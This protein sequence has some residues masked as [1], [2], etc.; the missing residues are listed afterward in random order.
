MFH[1][2]DCTRKTSRMGSHNAMTLQALTY[3]E[4]HWR[5]DGTGSNQAWYLLKDDGTAENRGL[6]LH[7]CNDL[8]NSMRHDYMNR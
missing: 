1:E 5:I 7:S 6:G 3:K 8:V 4:R 2:R